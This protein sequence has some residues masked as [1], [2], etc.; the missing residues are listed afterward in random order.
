MRALIIV[1]T[2]TRES[3]AIEVG[4]GIC[5]LHVT[6]TP[7]RIIGERGKPDSLRCDNRPEFT[8]RHFIGRCEEHRTAVIHIQPGKPMQNGHVESFNGRF[9]ANGGTRI[10]S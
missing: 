9:R 6:R 8:S 2:Y 3:P 7:E 1:D 4:T 5:S 10:S